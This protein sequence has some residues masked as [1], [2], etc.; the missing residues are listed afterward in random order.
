MTNFNM[1][2]L[3]NNQ[4]KQF[5]SDVKSLAKLVASA[6]GDAGKKVKFPVVATENA[7]CR[8]IGYSSMSELRMYSVNRVFD[9]KFSILK[10]DEKC[11]ANALTV[12]GKNDRELEKYLVGSEVVTTALNKILK[13]QA[14]PK[15]L[16]I[17]DTFIFLNELHVILNRSEFVEYQYKDGEFPNEFSIL[18]GDDF[19]A[20]LRDW[21]Q[22]VV[23]DGE[24]YFCYTVNAYRNMYTKENM[25]K[26]VRGRRYEN[27]FCSGMK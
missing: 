21:D 19:F 6:L 5:K 23:I 7:F 10:L 18:A 2:R 11:V 14:K 20:S 13:E 16:A 9:D 12:A 1:P 3:T 22:F 25:F 4:I 15:V 8:E 26:V 24:E 17:N 27:G